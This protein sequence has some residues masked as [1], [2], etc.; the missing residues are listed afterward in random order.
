MSS[1]GVG[2]S[3]GN[4]PV[5][6]GS[7]LK[8]IDRR[9]RLAELILRCLICGLAVLSA[10]LIGTDT[11]VREFFTIRKRA[12]FTD[13]KAL[14][15]LVIANGIA[16]GYSLVQVLRCVLSMIKGTVLFNK[17]LAW[18]IFSGDQVMTYLTLSAVAAAVQSGLFAQ[19]G[20]T[21]LQW[22]KTCNLYAKFCNQVGEGVASSLLACLS[23]VLL[24]AISAYGLFRLYGDN[25]GK[26]SGRW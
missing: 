25:K 3:P 17:P 24:S 8:V 26:S 20:Q 16:A 19:F 13:M 2:V 7:N 9:V 23:M 21:E 15:F 4:V 18:A 10:V 1:L 5:Y 12:K 22:M 14:V 11:Q 6:H